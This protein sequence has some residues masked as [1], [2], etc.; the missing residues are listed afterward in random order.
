VTKELIKGNGPVVRRGDHITV[1]Y[2]GVLYRGGREFDASWRRQ[3]PF[4]FSFGSGEVISGWERGII[5]MRAGSRRE[6]II[7]SALA[8][9]AQ[10]A[11]PTI[12]PNEALVFV[13]DLLRI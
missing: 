12:P 10:G 13:V 8:Y 6:L 2:V 4:T 11:S 9:G 5:G 7:P 3:E 1:N